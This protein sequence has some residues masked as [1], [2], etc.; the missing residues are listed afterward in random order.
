[1]GAQGGARGAD[2]AGPN[3]PAATRAN[4]AAKPAGSGKPAFI[5]KNNTHETPTEPT[6]GA[7][8]PVGESKTFFFRR[9]NLFAQISILSPKFL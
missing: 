9:S 3:M 2:A 4:G 7:A 6:N 5:K 1:M 8:V